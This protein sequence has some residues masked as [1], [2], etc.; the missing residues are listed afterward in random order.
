MPMRGRHRIPTIFTLSMLDVFCCALGCVILLWLWNER[1][2]KTRLKAAEETGRQ[3]DY[4]RG[5]LADARRMIEGL[6]GNVAALTSE[7][8]QTRSALAAAEKSI[9]GLKDDLS[10][11]R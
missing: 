9:G 3:L 6:K 8:D 7:R 1:L 5:E 10:A 2:A 4:A 11:A